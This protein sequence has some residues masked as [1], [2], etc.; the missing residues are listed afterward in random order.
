MHYRGS[1]QKKYQVTRLCTFFKK[2]YVYQ[3]QKVKAYTSKSKTNGTL[4]QKYKLYI[5]LSLPLTKI[6]NSQK[7]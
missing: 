5:S 4:L 3:S 1:L 6:T 7:F 2:V